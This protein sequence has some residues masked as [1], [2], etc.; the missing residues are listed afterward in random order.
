MEML[1]EFAQEMTH[2]FMEIARD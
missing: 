2:E 1:R